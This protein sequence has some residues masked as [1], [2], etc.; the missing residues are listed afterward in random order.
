[1]AKME[2]KE[3]QMDTKRISRNSYKVMKGN[4][5]DMKQIKIFFYGLMSRQTKGT[6]LE[7]KN[8][9]DFEH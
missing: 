4:L 3:E 1:M 2:K 7:K 6:K 5:I 9:F 8:T